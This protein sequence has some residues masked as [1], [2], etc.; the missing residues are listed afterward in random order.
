MGVPGFRTSGDQSLGASQQDWVLR[1]EVLVREE[2]RLLTLGRAAAAVQLDDPL[3]KD[4]PGAHVRRL[5][6]RAARRASVGRSR[7]HNITKTRV[8]VKLVDVR[9]AAP[10]TGQDDVLNRLEG[11]WESKDDRQ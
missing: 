6:L 1:G 3:A 7:D 9:H 8:S 10:N 5:L 4:V 11:A 2:H